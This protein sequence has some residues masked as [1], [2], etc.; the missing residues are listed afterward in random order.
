MARRRYKKKMPKGKGFNKPR[1]KTSNPTVNFSMVKKYFVSSATVQPT[2]PQI[3]IGLTI[4]VATPFS[5]ID[6]TTN[7]AG[8]W[9]DEDSSLV[10]PMGIAS[11]LYTGYRHLVVNGCKVTVQIK[12]NQ[13]IPANV[14]A[15]Q[16][17]TMGMINLIRTSTTAELPHTIATDNAVLRQSYGIKNKP[18]TF[19]T[20]LAQGRSSTLKLGFSA[21]KQFGTTARSQSGRF[22]VDNTAGSTNTCSDPTFIKLFISPSDLV[23]N[24]VLKDFRVNIKLEWNITFLEPTVAR[25][26][27]LPINSNQNYG[28]SWNKFSKFSK[29]IP[30]ASYGANAIAGAG[31]YYAYKAPATFAHRMRYYGQMP[32]LGYRR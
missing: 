22:W 23:N 31:A 12:D 5:S 4:D 2:G 11:D 32:R 6:T 25:G 7:A 1:V 29:Y 10:E 16:T 26:I 19:S 27:P 3:P 15:L 18:F 8:T 9:Q 17:Q 28:Y 20:T 24:A 21:K 30:Y 14:G 13:D